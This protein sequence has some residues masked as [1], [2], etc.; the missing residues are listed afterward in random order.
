MSFQR[1]QSSGH[2]S[3]PLAQAPATYGRTRESRDKRF[4]RM[5]QN[6]FCFFNVR[7]GHELTRKVQ[8]NLDGIVQSV[9]IFW[10]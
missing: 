9:F 2:A 1:N 10:N 4:Y 7:V 6:A 8:L 5:H 3:L